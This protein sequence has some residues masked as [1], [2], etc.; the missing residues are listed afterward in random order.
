MDMHPHD[1]SSEASLIHAAQAGMP[2]AMDELL[3]RHR[4]VLYGTARRFTNSHEDAE[5]LVQDAMLRAFINIRK[6][7]GDARFRTWL[8]AIVNNTALSMKRKQKAAC[9][10]SIDDTRKESYDS[11]G[12][13]FPDSS[14]SPEQE[15]IW[16]E[17]VSVLKTAIS[18]KSQRYQIVIRACMLN[19]QSAREAAPALGITIASAKSRLFRVR[20]GLF[21]SFVRRG[22]VKRRAVD[23]VGT[24]SAISSRKRTARVSSA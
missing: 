23:T 7:R 19:E 15:L 20:R 22:L 11:P 18:A 14:F 4:G 10:I 24:V 8:V 6:F 9:W 1:A 21:E 3:V 2:G 12:W 17:F 13:E 16:Q 5:D